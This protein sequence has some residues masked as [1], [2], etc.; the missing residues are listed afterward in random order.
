MQNRKHTDGPQGGRT[1]SPVEA[2]R[3]RRRAIELEWRIATSGQ[4]V[5]Q[6]A[7]Q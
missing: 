4:P 5:G 2:R 7:R 1:T 6:W 3:T